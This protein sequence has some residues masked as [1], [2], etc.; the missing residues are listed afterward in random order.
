MGLLERLFGRA[1]RHTAP[2]D[3]G[4]QQATPGQQVLPR[5]SAVPHRAQ[6]PSRALS[7][8]QA[9]ERYRDLVRTAPP[10]TLEQ[11]HREAFARLTPEQ[12]ARALRELNAS[13][14]PSERLTR[15]DP[16][17]LARMATRAELL[18]PGTVV[19]ALGGPGFGAGR[20]PGM[21]MGS[22]MAGGLLSSLVG[23]AV[24]SVLA[25]QLLDRFQEDPHA[26]GGGFRDDSS[27]D[28]MDQEADASD[29]DHAYGADA[30]GTSQEAREPDW[31]GTEMDVGG[32]ADDW[33]ADFGMDD[34]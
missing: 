2:R 29:L 20:G 5:P 19:S 9:L 33:S 24:G 21:G 17:S 27:G 13:V 31:G 6:A 10:E 26:R 32:G 16:E 15:D 12:R 23:S 18:R 7:D 25:H 8:E 28:V 30:T 3:T 1:P 22:M 4:P 11:I 14:G 34:F